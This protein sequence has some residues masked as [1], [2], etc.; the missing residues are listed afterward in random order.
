LDF[1]VKLNQFPLTF[2][3]FNKS[4]NKLF[5]DLKEYL[6]FKLFD[7]KALILE[8]LNE[9]SDGLSDKELQFAINAKLSLF[10]PDFSV[11]FAEVLKIISYLQH[12]DLI[13]SY[14]L[15]DGSFCYLSKDQNLQLVK[16]L[17]SSYD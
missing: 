8:L 13:S 3:S 9:S 1:F 2:G 16:N 7:F 14:Q 15:E 12:D 6:I 17:V 5:D 11:S 10:I 4:Q